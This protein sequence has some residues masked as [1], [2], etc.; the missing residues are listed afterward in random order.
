MTRLSCH[1]FRSN[2]VRLAL[3]LLAYNLGN[4]WRRLAL[5]KRIENWSLSEDGWTA[6]EAC[7]L[8]LAVVGG[9]PSDAAALWEHGETDCGAAAASRV[10]KA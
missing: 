9:E 1:R 2:Q 7:T 5:P 10:T 4:L 3:S 6:G 8:L